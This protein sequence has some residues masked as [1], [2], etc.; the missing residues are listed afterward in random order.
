MLARHCSA[1]TKPQFVPPPIL[2]IAH[3]LGGSA[4][5]VPTKIDVAV[6]R[7]LIQIDNFIGVL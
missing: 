6:N 4:E 1:V 7:Q 3:H 5:A 2:S